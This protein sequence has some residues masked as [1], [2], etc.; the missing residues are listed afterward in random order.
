MAILEVTDLKKVYTT[1]LGGQQVEA[2]KNVSFSVDQGEYVAV[3]GESGSG[4][5]TLLNILAALDSPTAG[6][7]KLEART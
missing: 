2:L 5:T 3:M 6:S 4:K 1:R 7:V